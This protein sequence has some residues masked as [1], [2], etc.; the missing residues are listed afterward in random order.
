MTL[1]DVAGPDS[2]ERLHTTE[3]SLCG[4]VRGEDYEQFAAHLAQ[5][6]EWADLGLDRDAD[7]ELDRDTDPDPAPEPTDTNIERVIADD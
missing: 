5:Q 2:W 7:P 3:C 1:E 6:H 4:A